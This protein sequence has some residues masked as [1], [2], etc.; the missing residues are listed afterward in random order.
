MIV[1][2]PAMLLDAVQTFFFSVA[3]AIKV[4]CRQARGI[5]PELLLP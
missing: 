4:L 2:G 1:V 5:A 3:A